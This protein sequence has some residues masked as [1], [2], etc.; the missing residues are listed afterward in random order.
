MINA[1]VIA[2]SVN[3]HTG[4]VL[5]TF[6]VE[7][8]RIIHS[9]MLTHRLFSRN[10]ASS[11]AVPVLKMIER[12]QENSFTPEYIG[13]NQRGMAADLEV[14]DSTRD[15]A[16]RVWELAKETA[17]IHS[18]RLA[19]LGVHKQLSNRVTEPYQ[20]I[21]VVI[22]ATCFKNWYRLRNHSAAQ[23]EIQALAYEMYKADQ[24]FGEAILLNKGDWHLPYIN[25][26]EKTKYTIN[27]QLLM[28]VARCARV[29]YFLRDGSTTNPEKDLA[30]AK[31]LMSESHWSPTEHVAM[32][33]PNKD[34]IG[35]FIGF[36]Q[37]RKFFVSEHNGDLE[38]QR[39][40]TP[41]QAIKEYGEIYNVSGIKKRI[42]S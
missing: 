22:T 14:S 7:Y 16:I 29:S 18:A 25:E 19:N 27:D 31:R 40:L 2:K 12:V 41:K 37:L 38:P 34:M 39:I 23:P 9:E 42:F 20:M 17:L 28:S 15:E 24:E 4:D 13:K 33:I 30:L 8:P 35:N 5:T 32:A 10:S 1:E 3:T 6:Q 26:E 21:Q 11:R 36:M